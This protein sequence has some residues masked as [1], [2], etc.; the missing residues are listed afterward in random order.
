M[1]Q[2]IWSAWESEARRHPDCRAQFLNRF[3]QFGA[4]V[5]AAPF[6]D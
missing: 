4:R 3:L 1:K 6:A 5:R 2:G